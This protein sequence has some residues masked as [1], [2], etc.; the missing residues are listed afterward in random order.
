MNKEQYLKELKRYLRRLPREE[1]EDAMD[2]FTECFDEA[3]VE[4]EQQLIA[5]LGTPKEAA[6]EVFGNLLEKEVG[7]Q[8]LIVHEQ[9][10]GSLLKGVLI[11]ILAICAAPIGIPLLLVILALIFTA[12]CIIA[13]LIL[14]VVCVVIAGFLAGGKLFLRGVLAIPFSMSGAFIIIGTGVFGIGIGIIA[15]AVTMFACKWSARA[16]MWLTRKFLKRGG[17]RNDTE[18]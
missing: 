18:E 2:Y 12:I 15:I 1:Y 8:E 4:G 14:C 10:E 5:E 3:G 6:R 11:A 13:S 16:F 7:K 17:A 9:K